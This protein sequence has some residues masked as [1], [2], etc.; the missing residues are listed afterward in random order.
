MQSAAQRGKSSSQVAVRK[1]R[2]GERKL[3]ENFAKLTK[4]SR[5]RVI[6]RQDSTRQNLNKTHLSAARLPEPSRHERHLSTTRW[7][8]ESLCCLVCNGMGL[9]SPQDAGEDAEAKRKG[10]QPM[11]RWDTVTAGELVWPGYHSGLR[12]TDGPTRCNVRTWH[13]CYIT[14]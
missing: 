8:S 10:L 1:T 12:I 2:E 13:V 5:Y 14:R 9:L 6:V 4:A 11:L 3:P 7:G